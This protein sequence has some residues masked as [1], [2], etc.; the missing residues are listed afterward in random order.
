[1]CFTIE[2]TIIVSYRHFYQKTLRELI[3]AQS[4]ITL[5]ST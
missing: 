1:M 4:T 2:S 3:F 5:L